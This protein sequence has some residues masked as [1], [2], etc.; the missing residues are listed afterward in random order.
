MRQECISLI[1]DGY[2]PEYAGIRCH[3]GAR[4]SLRHRA[5]GN[6]M[7]IVYPDTEDAIYVYK[8]NRLVKKVF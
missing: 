4:V 8:N 2:Y 1:G 5:N 7:I 6:H 3:R